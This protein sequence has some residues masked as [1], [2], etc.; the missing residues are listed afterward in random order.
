MHVLPARA[1]VLLLVNRVIAL[2]IDILR[3]YQSRVC[4]RSEMHNF[5]DFEKKTSQIHIILCAP[6]TQ[7]S[8]LAKVNRAYTTNTESYE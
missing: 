2:W 4:A 1:D 8:A 3:S 7:R 5:G 6:S